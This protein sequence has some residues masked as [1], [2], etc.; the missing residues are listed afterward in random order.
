MTGTWPPACAHDRSPAGA[1]TP[2]DFRP[3][4][5]MTQRNPMWLVVVSIASACARGRA[6]AQAVVGGAQVRA[7]LDDATRDMSAGGGVIVA[8]LR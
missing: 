4:S 5:F 2:R 7:A 6:V 1:L 3:G 8:G